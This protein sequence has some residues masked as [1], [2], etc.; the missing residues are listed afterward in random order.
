MN[1]NIS[2]EKYFLEKLKEYQTATL[3]EAYGKKGALPSA[4]KPLSDSFS[5]TGKAVTVDLRPADNIVLHHAIYEAEKGDVLVVDA[6]GYTEAGVWGEIM[7]YA[8]FLRGI[9]GLVVYGCVRDKKEIIDMGFPVFSIGTCI[10]GTTKFA[11]GSINESISIGGII[12]EKGDYIR[13]NSDGVIVI[14]GKDIKE[15]LANA[16]RITEKEKTIITQLKEG[17]TTLQTYNFK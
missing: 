13:G 9:A 1:D 6:K 3:H 16:E 14:K 8:A 12:I 4:I 5:V 10:K 15:V 7:S 17:R 2:N 11:P